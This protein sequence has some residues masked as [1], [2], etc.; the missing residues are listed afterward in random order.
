MIVG[1]KSRVYISQS[2]SLSTS[3]SLHL[4]LLDSSMTWG[5][6]ELQYLS[7]LTKMNHVVDHM[8]TAVWQLWFVSLSLNFAFLHLSG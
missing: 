6:G 5:G 7:F 4:A 2:F 8:W 1:Y 3:S